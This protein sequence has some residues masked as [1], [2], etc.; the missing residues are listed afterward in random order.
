VQN[1]PIVTAIQLIHNTGNVFPRTVD[2]I[3]IELHWDQPEKSDGPSARAT[4][5]VWEGGSQKTYGHLS[6]DKAVRAWREVRAF[7]AW[8]NR[9]RA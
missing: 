5:S 1:T 6:A 8:W 3:E 2:G 9:P 4:W 7:D